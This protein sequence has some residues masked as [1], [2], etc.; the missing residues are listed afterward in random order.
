VGAVDVP[1]PAWAALR[2]GD[3]EIETVRPLEEWRVGH[4][5]AFDLRLEAQSPPAEL[6]AGGEGYEQVVRVRGRAGGAQ[7][8]AAG[9]RGHGWGA[10]D[11]D[12]LG[13]LRSVSAW[14]EGGDAVMVRSAHPARANG[15]EDDAIAAALVEGA[16]EREPIVIPVQEP[17][18]STTWDAEG[19]QRRAGLEL[20]VGEEDGYPRRAAGEA[21]CGTTL[22]LG[23]L[24]LDLAFLRWEMEGR[25]GP[26]RYEVLRRA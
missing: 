19:R 9:Q 8:D 10:L 13:S 16:G 12:A 25:A 17:R 21:V 1:A 22:E 14:L 23:R 7:V 24:R 15:H 26:G 4:G 3:M 18:L 11:W 5:E 6:A 20:W 2:A